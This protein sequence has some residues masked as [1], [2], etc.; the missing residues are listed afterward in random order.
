[1]LFR[2]EVVHR[3]LPFGQL[4]FGVNLVSGMFFFIAAPQE[5][6]LNISFHWKVIFL[7]LTGLSYHV[8]AVYDRLWEQPADGSVT[9]TQRFVGIFGLVSYLGVMYFGRMLPFIGNA[10]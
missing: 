10:F 3:L 1:M 6:V 9:G 7:A 4:G 8:I 5:Y 2:S